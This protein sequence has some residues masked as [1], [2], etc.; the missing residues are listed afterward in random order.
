MNE[1][2]IAASSSSIDLDKIK[3][4]RLFGSSFTDGLGREI[5][6]VARDKDLLMK[7]A[8]SLLGV[9]TLDDARV[10]EVAV[11]PVAEYDNLIALARRAASIFAGA[12]P[13]R[14]IE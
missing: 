9:S 11:L 6:L 3:V 12:V 7:K 4:R 5:G 2:H 14:G 13:E 10:Y 1:N 8:D